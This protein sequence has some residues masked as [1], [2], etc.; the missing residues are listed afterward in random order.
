MGA[1]DTLTP[2][3]SDAAAIATLW[4]IFLAISVVV[5]LA[6]I[7]AL[8]IAMRRARR[9]TA[10]EPA[11]RLRSDDRSRL[12]IG[13]AMSATLLVLLVM[14][15]GDFVVGRGVLGEHAPAG[16]P[17][18]IRITAH[19]F[20]WQI[21]YEDAD[22][23]A[24]IATANELTVPTG[25]PVELVLSSHDVIHSFWLPAISGKKDLIPGITNSMR[26][27]VNQPGRYEGQCAEFCGYQHANMRTSMNAVSPDQFSK[28][29]KQQREPSAPPG[30]ERAR[31]GRDV[32]LNSS[33]IACHSVRGTPAAATVGPDLTHFAG[34]RTIAA[35]PYPNTAEWLAAWI[36]SP[37]R[38]KP[39]TS[40]PAT[41][42]PPE[43]LAAVVHYL[44]S[45]K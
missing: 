1:H 14:L 6:V 18:R 24:A 19:Q 36:S 25:R 12:V 31:R 40:M 10:A 37:Q 45:L 20:W 44:G 2:G 38:L 13:A 34:R 32:F 4:W 21:D 3:G 33:C 43:D 27:S 16:S 8:V 9:G 41:P 11:Q 23:S 30:D 42:L 39:G 5:Y 26:F 35:G 15:A 29:Q 28:W 7:A 22:P 17:L